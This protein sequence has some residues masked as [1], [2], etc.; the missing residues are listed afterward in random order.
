MH[1]DREEYVLLPW[2]PRFIMTHCQQRLL[3]L[4]VLLAFPSFSF[5][6]GSN[7]T[8]TLTTA[9]L[10]TVCADSLL[11]WSGG[12]P[13]YWVYMARGDSPIGNNSSLDPEILFIA[14]LNDTISVITLNRSLGMSL[15]QIHN[16]QNGS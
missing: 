2:N 12:L 5:A 9:S 7:A 1:S 3:L 16:L 6:Q 13:P 8:F 10:A 14:A 4:F 11:E 15:N